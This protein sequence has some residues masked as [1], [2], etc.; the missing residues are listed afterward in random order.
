MTR[1]PTSGVPRRKWRLRYTLRTV[2]VLVTVTC[3]GL[4]LYTQRVRRQQQI[5]ERIRHKS[6]GWTYDYHNK[7]NVFH[8]RSESWVPSWLLDCLGEDFFHCIT[9]VRIHDESLAEAATLPHLQE[10]AIIDQGLTDAKL[11]TLRGH[12]RLKRLSIVRVG[13]R[14]SGCGDARDVAH[15]TDRSLA[16]MGELPALDEVYVSSG[17]FSAQG[18]RDL[19]HGPRLVRVRLECCDASVTPSVAELFRQHSTVRSLYLRRRTASGE[20]EVVADWTR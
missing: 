15:I 5:V 4:A 8:A 14:F 9:A 16:L 2:L 3:I 11:A 12:R 6:G 7:N 18:L 10:L 20:E 17:H 19:A 1:Q 13:P